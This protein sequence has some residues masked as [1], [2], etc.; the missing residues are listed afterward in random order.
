MIGFLRSIL[1]N[2]NFLK[3]RKIT[4]SALKALSMLVF[5]TKTQASM[6]YILSHKDILEIVMMISYDFTD[7]D[8]TSYFVNIIKSLVNHAKETSLTLFYNSRYY[9]FPLLYRLI[10]FYNHPEGLIRT[11]VQ[12]C[13]IGF[14]NSIYRIVK[15][16]R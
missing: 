10:S 8:I 1:R 12:N 9:Y 7:Y 2:A 3:I 4:I 6:F 16:S 15:I 13:V 5:N 14:I 11:T